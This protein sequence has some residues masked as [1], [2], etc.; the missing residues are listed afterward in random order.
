VLQLLDA[1]ALPV[2]HG[3]SLWTGRKHVVSEYLENEEVYVRTDRWK[4]IYGSGR[5]ARQDGYLTSTPTPGRYARLFDLQSDRDE[6]VDQ[7]AHQPKVAADMAKLALERFRTTHPEAAREPSGA[8]SESALD[9][10][11]RPRDNAP[12]AE[13]KP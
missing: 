1:P 10:Y 8:S 2:Q 3:K 13:Q 7:S 12:P 4:Y 9:F 5:R 6:F 11:L